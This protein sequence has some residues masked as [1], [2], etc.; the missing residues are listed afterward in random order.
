LPWTWLARSRMK[1]SPSDHAGWKSEATAKPPTHV[2]H[3]TGAPGCASNASRHG[4]VRRVRVLDHVV[5]LLRSLEPD[6]ASTSGSTGRVSS[7]VVRQPEV[8][9]PHTVRAAASRAVGSCPPTVGERR[10]TTAGGRTIR[11]VA[12]AEQIPRRRRSPGVGNPSGGGQP[13]EGDP[14]GTLQQGVMN[15]RA[16]QGALLDTR[17]K[18]ASSAAH[19]AP[20]RGVRALAIGDVHDHAD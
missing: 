12:P 2:E 8:G 9:T 11:S 19:R 4:T 7:Y 14:G 5:S 15:V 1:S 13:L 20:Q 18:R 6:T 3:G 10:S 16:E 17:T